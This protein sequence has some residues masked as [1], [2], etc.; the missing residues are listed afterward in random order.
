VQPVNATQPLRKWD[1]YDAY[2]F[3]IDGTLL[4]CHDAVHYFAFCEALTALAGREL[5]LDGVVAH[6]NTDVAAGRRQRKSSD[7]RMAQARAQQPSRPFFQF[8][9]F[10]DGY[11]YAAM[12][13]APWSRR[14]GAARIPAQASAWSAISHPISRPLATTI[15]T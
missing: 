11:E 1:A 8:G 15:S 6:G 14:Y 9:G 7:H 5:N 13:S 2:L 10:S 4:T 3:D 12:S